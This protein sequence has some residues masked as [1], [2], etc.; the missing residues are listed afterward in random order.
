M[1]GTHMSINNHLP[2]SCRLSGQRAD[3]SDMSDMSASGVRT[4]K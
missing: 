1:P 3:M 4:R 2:G